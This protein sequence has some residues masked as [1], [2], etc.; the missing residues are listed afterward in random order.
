MQALLFDL[1]G[2]LID[3]AYAHALAWQYAFLQHGIT[4]D[5]WRLH[6][7]IGMSGD[8]L[9]QAVAEEFDVHLKDPDAMSK[10]HAKKFKSILPALIPHRGAIALLTELRRRKV[11]FGIATSGVRKDIQPSLDILSLKKSDVVVTRDEVAEG[12]PHEDL[13]E[14][15]RRQL[16]V[17]VEACFAVGDSVWD[18]LSAKRGR[19]LFVGLLSGG[20]G[21]EELA[22]A[23][24]YRI[25]EDTEALRLH[26][27]ELGLQPKPSKSR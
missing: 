10:A 7:R 1:D 25:Y 6:R 16:D 17:P 21:R 9:M 15:C 13:F 12:K 19:M 2:T 18:A 22:D 14:A 3:S 4:V 20:Y 23:G 5:A 26:L 24:A 27:P 8:V 11:R